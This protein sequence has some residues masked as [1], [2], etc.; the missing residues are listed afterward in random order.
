MLFRFSSV[1]L[2]CV[3]LVGCGRAKVT[4]TVYGA[5]GAPQGPVEQVIVYD[6]QLPGWTGSEGRQVLN[7][8]ADTMVA[9]LQSSGLAARRAAGEPYDGDRIEIRGEFVQVD[10]GSTVGRTVV[11]FGFG[12][13][14]VRSKVTVGRRGDDDKYH[15]VAVFD[16]ET[17]GSKMPGLVVP[18]A[19]GSRVGLAVGGGTKAVSELSGP[20]ATD[21]KRT[22]TAVAQWTAGVLRRK[23]WMPER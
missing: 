5:H 9:E 8:V 17:T 1:L 2:V 22:G 11:G 16:T 15:M 12:S 6:F 19:A 23:G 18:A 13:S 10:K 3:C 21:A 4:E 14:K 7:L 20:V